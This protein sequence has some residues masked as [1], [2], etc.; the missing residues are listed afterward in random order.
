MRNWQ[1]PW[2]RQIPQRELALAVIESPLLRWYNVET[3]H[4]NEVQP[5]NSLY[6]YI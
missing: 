2:L 5:I 6:T 1:Q 3:H 4:T